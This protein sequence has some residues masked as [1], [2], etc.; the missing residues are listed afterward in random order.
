MANYR[1]MGHPS[2]R[3]LNHLSFDLRMTVPCFFLDRRSLICWIDM[4]LKGH[5]FI[6]RLWYRRLFPSIT[7]KYL[8]MAIIVCYLGSTR[9]ELLLIS[10]YRRLY[11]R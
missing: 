7:N 1:M 9:A 6:V 3:T 5:S 11:L 8:Q 10:L 4:A 2:F